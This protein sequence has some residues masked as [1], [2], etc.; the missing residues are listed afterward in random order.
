MAHPAELGDEIARVPP[1]QF[2]SGVCECTQ[3]FLEAGP[4]IRVIA[5]LLGTARQELLTHT[6]QLFLHL[7]V[8]DEVH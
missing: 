3:P 6:F 2:R 7:P 5:V 8:T 4:R 1:C